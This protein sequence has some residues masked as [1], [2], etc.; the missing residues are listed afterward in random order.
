MEDVV[1][2]IHGVEKDIAELSSVRV[3]SSAR[4]HGG[5]DVWTRDG[6]SA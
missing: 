5:G 1:E 4:P 3:A 2:L 6:G